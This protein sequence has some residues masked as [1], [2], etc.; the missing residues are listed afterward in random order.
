MLVPILL[1]LNISNSLKTSKSGFCFLFI[2]KKKKCR[3]KVV[4]NKL[5]LNLT[6]LL[7]PDLS[8]A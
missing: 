1:S 8:A 5:C 2:K 7:Y 4:A 3:C 6:L